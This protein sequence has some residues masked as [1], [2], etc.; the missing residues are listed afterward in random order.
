MKAR[1]G[2][3]IFF[4]S[5]ITMGVFFSILYFFKA[6][7]LLSILATL[8]GALLLSV[9]IHN[10]VMRQI[11]LLTVYTKEIEKG[12]ISYKINKNTCVEMFQLVEA[13]D[14]MS[15]DM[16]INLGQVVITSEKLHKEVNTTRVQYSALESSYMGINE[17]IS[18]IAKAIEA[19]AQQ[20]LLTKET[21]D[22][23]MASLL[24][25][26]ASGEETEQSTNEMIGIVSEVNDKTKQI[27][28][29]TKH[30]AMI[31][32]AEADKILTL[33]S[34]MKQIEG[35][36]QI[37]TRISE[38]TN[39]LALNASIEAARAGE[40]GR[41]FAVVA[42]EVRKLAEESSASTESIAGIISLVVNQTKEIAQSL[43]KSGDEAQKN[44]EFADESNSSIVELNKV[45][46][47][48]MA[49]LAIM[50]DRI[51][52]QKKASEKVSHL[53]EAIFNENQSITANIQEVSSLSDQQ[54]N[55]LSDMTESI[56]SINNV[57]DELFE[58]SIKHKS[59]IK[60]D[61]ATRLKVDN[62]LKIYKDFIKNL[63]I[64]N[65][66]NFRDTDLKA[67]V[68]QNSDYEF[69]AL[70]DSF[71]I[72]HQFSE[73]VGASTID[74][75]Y[76]PFYY[77]TIKGHDYISEPYISSITNEYC[78]TVATPIKSESKIS[79]VAVLDI[80]L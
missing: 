29:G 42:E 38:Q 76:R 44:I 52:A 4:I 2:V 77:E 5:L 10:R 32:K 47:A 63:R 60:I 57:S 46:K 43:T 25:V 65:V 73:D 55:A 19:T 68:N 54:M 50:F 3:T 79:G 7:I 71:G 24:E 13:I 14:S 69:A 66:V 72:A 18:E 27:I 70:L 62:C 51:E 39:L 8:L 17:N 37:I 41:G 16:K 31:I 48:S 30:T 78:I 15:K 20:S 49:Q 34:N 75:S 11:H 22:N 28:D 59:G 45:M 12:N 36:I 56:K 74:V 40:A 35:I 33:E 23:M 53:V 58:M 80:T 6:S 61:E 21:T 67:F 64:E 26:K 9:L 1:F